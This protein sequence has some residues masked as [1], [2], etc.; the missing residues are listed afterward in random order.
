MNIMPIW[1]GHMKKARNGND[2]RRTYKGFKR[3]DE[4][5]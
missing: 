4:Q 2:H 3:K 5:R 1:Y